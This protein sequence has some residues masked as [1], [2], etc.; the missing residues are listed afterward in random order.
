MEEKLCSSY[1]V[2]AIPSPSGEGS[3][4][5]FP[6]SIMREAHM[7]HSFHQLLQ[8]GPSPLTAVLQAQAVPVL[9]PCWITSPAA[10]L[11]QYGT[12]SP[13]LH[14]SCWKHTPE[15]ASQRDTC[16]SM[17]PFRGSRC[18]PV[19]LLVWQGHS[20]LTVVLTMSCR[21]MSDLLPAAP[22]PFLLH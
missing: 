19:D 21:G 14:R 16:S 15:W 13:W 4:T 9:V 10:N 5:L 17:G 18:F 12:L 6:C 3:L 7:R 20:C 8:C 2:S 1:I 11:L 22:P